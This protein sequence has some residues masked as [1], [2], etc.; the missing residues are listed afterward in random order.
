MALEDQDATLLHTPKG[1]SYHSVMPF[2]LKNARATYQRVMQTIWKDMLRKMVECYTNDLVV[3]SKK[4]L[5]HLQDLR[6]IF[7]RL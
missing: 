2:G 5:D 7:K 3:K 6:Q 4:K 1:V